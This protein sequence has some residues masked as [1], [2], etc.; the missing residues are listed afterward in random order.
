VPAANDLI[1]EVV[2]VVMKLLMLKIKAIFR[3]GKRGYIYSIDV[4]L[5]KA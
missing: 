4:L 3:Q 5:D 2:L 1:A